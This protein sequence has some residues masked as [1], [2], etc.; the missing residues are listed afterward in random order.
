MIVA[1]PAR[2][3]DVDHSFFRSLLMFKGPIQTDLSQEPC[4]TLMR[5]VVRTSDAVQAF[6]QTA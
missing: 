2:M 1:R 4:A 3:V 6:Q 5:L